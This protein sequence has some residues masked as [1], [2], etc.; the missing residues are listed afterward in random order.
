MKAQFWEGQK[1][2]NAEILVK[3]DPSN[4]LVVFEAAQNKFEL[5]TDLV[6]RSPV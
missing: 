6:C 1:T 3:L 5:A 2:S 4:R